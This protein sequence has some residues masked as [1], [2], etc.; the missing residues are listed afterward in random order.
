M[1]EGRDWGVGGTGTHG[2]RLLRVEGVA[3]PYFVCPNFFAPKSAQNLS[4]RG[5]PIPATIGTYL[6]IYTYIYCMYVHILY[7]R[8]YIMFISEQVC[9]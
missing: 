3:D 4:Q 9:V 6:Y 2:G 1:C 7:V 8:T 5:P